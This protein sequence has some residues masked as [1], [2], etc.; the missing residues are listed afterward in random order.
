MRI[1]Y[2]DCFA[3]AAGDMI[4]AALLDAGCDLREL[5]S[6]LETLWADG[7]ELRCEAATRRGIHGARFFVDVTADQPSRHLGDILEMIR[8]AS[9]P[10]R[11]ADNAC[12]I[13][14]RLAEAEAKVHGIEVERCTSTRS[15]R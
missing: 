11:A 4:V 7:Y 12:K 10:P 15:G 1:A 5:S 8:A 3:G 13:F 6:A 2:F 14:A 9:L